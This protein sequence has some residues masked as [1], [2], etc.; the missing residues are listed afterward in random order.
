MENLN[1]KAE[2]SNTGLL[3]SLIHK[4]SGRFVYAMV[5]YVSMI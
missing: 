5:L 2:I 4:K 3:R 1:I